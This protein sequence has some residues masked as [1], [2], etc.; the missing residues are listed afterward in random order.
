ML[1][2]LT[3]DLRAFL[4]AIAPTLAFVPML[5][6]AGFS[7][8]WLALT[9]VPVVGLFFVWRFAF[10]EWPAHGERKPTLRG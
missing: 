6:K 8:W 3:L 5:R 2:H 1:T 9:Q 7:G 4:I 10:M